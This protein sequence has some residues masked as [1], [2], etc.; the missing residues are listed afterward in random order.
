VYLVCVDE[1]LANGELGWRRRLEMNAD[2][3]TGH[4]GVAGQEEGF[5]LLE[6]AVEA[7]ADGVGAQIGPVVSYSDDD[8]GGL[9]VACRHA[10]MKRFNF[11]NTH[12]TARTHLPQKAEGFLIFQH[13][14]YYNTS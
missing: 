1:S 5:A 10:E 7:V 12:S 9:I 3:C 11:I 13:C 8:A 2:K 14:P 6:E 4:R